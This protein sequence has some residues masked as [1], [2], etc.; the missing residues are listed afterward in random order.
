MD[1]RRKGVVDWMRYFAPEVERQI[2][3]G[4]EKFLRVRD[5]Y[6]AMRLSPDDSQLVREANEAIAAVDE[7]LDEIGYQSLS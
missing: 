4:N 6:E 1:E 3:G 5:A 2:Q 7:D